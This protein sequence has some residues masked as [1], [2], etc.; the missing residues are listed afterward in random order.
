[1]ALHEHVHDL[2]TAVKPVVTAV[3]DD[4]MDDPTPCPEWDVRALANHLLG[5]IEAF[6]RVGVAEPLDPDD[7]WGTGGDH[8]SDTWRDDLASR[9]DGFAGAWDTAEAYEGEVPG[10][11]MPK[12]VLGGM[13]FVEA[14]LHGWDLA[15]A[16]GQ[17]VAYDDAVVAEAVA[18]MEQIGATGRQMGAFGE[19]VEL[20]EDASALQ[21]VLA[22]AGR[23]PG[24][25]AP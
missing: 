2:V 1:M 14:L 5:T 10:A 19:L 6:R 21:H 25:T 11:Q 15:R 13:A 18:V 20:P 23:D 22:E 4:A 3:P 16:T 9:L 17:D 7:P 8:M 12:Q 24:W